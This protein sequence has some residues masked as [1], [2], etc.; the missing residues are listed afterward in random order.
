M[1]PVFAAASLVN[2]CVVI[3][4]TVLVALVVSSAAAVDTAPAWRGA[5]GSTLQAWSFDTGGNPAIPESLSNPFGVPSAAI[6]FNPPFGYGWYNSIPEVYGSAQGWWSVSRGSIVLSITN[7]PAIAG[8]NVSK[9]I[10]VQVTYWK[11]MNDA[12]DVVVTPSAT[13]VSN[14]TT[15][16]E[17]GPV[18][19][20]WYMALWTLR[21]D[22][23]QN[24]EIITVKG[25][26]TAGSQIDKII[27]DT[28][29]S[30][31]I[32]SA[33]QAR[34]LPEGTVV[35]LSGPVVTRAFS[36]FFYVENPNFASAIRV[37]CASGQAPAAENTAPT[38]TGVIRVVDGE[39]AIDQASVVPGGS[40]SVSPLGMPGRAITSG[41]IPQGMLVKLFGRATVASPTA[42]SFTLND[43]SPQSLPVELYG[44]QPPADGDYIAVTGAL[45]ANLDGP[46]LR[47]GLS[48]TITKLN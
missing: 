23:N 14:T 15:L 44:V 13:V 47:V 3:I 30:A 36:T 6:D 37:N 43:G 1:R 46:V 42:T 27:V 11:D 29:Y 40:G 31:V 41:L 9:D 5:P 34:T 32:A 39:R 12:P 25:H 20:A 10:Q 48:D 24:S 45:G 4:A 28:R 21:V 2:Q 26:A 22:P 38:V 7:N 16:V 8:I 33:A 35:A 17:N 19:G 18:G